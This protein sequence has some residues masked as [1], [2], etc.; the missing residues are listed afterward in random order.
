VYIAYDDVR[1]RKRVV[2]NTNIKIESQ[3]ELSEGK[4]INQSHVSFQD[5]LYNERRIR[6]YPAKSDNLA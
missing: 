2:W 6:G 3:T 4:M 5:W 1:E